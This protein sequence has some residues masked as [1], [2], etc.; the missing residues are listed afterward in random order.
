M[1][2]RK[3][4]DA[5]L[6]LGKLKEGRGEAEADGGGGVIARR[7][8][9]TE[10]R[11]GRELS[12][13]SC[14]SAWGEVG[15]ESAAVGSELAGGAEAGVAGVAVLEAKDAGGTLHHAG[16]EVV[17]QRYEVAVLVDDFDGDVS[18]FISSREGGL[19]DGGAQGIGSATGGDGACGSIGG[20]AAKCARLVFDVPIED[21]GGGVEFGFA[22]DGLVVEE[23]FGA[24]SIGVADDAHGL[25]FVVVPE[26]WGIG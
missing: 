10:G 18:H 15:E 3:G 19:V 12:A 26:G 16:D 20:F 14:L 2:V 7:L 23:E 9:G 22:A 13:G 5:H 17:G 6:Q 25:P 4:A 24:G 8:V 21:V 11:E 1:S